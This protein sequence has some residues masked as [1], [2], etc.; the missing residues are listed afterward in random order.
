M[1]QALLTTLYRLLQQK[2][3]RKTYVCKVQQEHW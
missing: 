2:A 3:V 1:A